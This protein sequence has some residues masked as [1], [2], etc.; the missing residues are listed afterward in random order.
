M[1][2]KVLNIIYTD[3]LKNIRT[4]FS[5]A[6]N[7]IW[8]KRN[9]IKVIFFLDKDIVMKSFRIPHMINKI[10]YTFLRDSKA[11][12]SY[13]NSLNIL[14]FVPKPIGFSE[15]KKFGLLH[16]SYFLCEKYEY[17]FTIREPLTQKDF[18]DK[19]LIFKQFA[20]FTY[21]LHKKGVEHLDYSPGNILIKKIADKVYE[22]KIIDVNR[23][24]FKVFTQEECLEN[25]SKLWADDEDLI[26]IIKAYVPFIHIKE[27]EAIDIALRASQKH[28]DKKNFKKKLFKHVKRKKVS[29]K[30]V[31]GQDSALHQISVAMMAKNAERT[32]AASLDSLIL[33]DE[34]LLYLNNSTDET[35]RIAQNYANVKVIEGEFL[36]FGKTK[37][38]AGKHCENDWILS[39]DSDEVLNNELLTEIAQ[40]D[41]KDI[42]K[43]YKL[44]RDNY[45]LG[46]KTQSS[47][48]I[49]RIYNKKYTEFDDSDVHEKIKIPKNTQVLKFKNNFKHLYI[50]NINQ[51]LT[52][53]IHYTDLGS[54]DK[55][56]CFFSVVIAKTVF[57]FFRTYI[58]EG[59][60]INGWRGYVLAVN[61]ANKR[62]Y[63]YLKQFINC[64]EEKKSK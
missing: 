43:L 25:F 47:D 10:A 59:N 57:A 16:D 44:K 22:F 23:M 52:K 8:D 15:F 46:G 45:F 61:S 62:H 33:F 63:K 48:V 9:K 56:M 27:K 20:A 36:G 4:Y 2:Y 54:K 51:T 21:A 49:V 40:I 34:V 35:K 12:R 42:S 30:N 60:I 14:E 53:I 58:L 13:Q 26:T 17:D 31:K 28:K 37:N 50:Q 41:I 24:K 7:S 19:E 29:N 1:R 38:E 39:L 32:I 64:Q 5:E 18:N 11:E 3:L 55:K 6:N